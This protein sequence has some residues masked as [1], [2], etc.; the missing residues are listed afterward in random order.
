MRHTVPTSSAICS[1]L[2]RRVAYHQKRRDIA[3]GVEHTLDVEKPAAGIRNCTDRQELFS[4][5]MSGVNS[6]GVA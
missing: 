6:Y 5:I 1:G 3:H 4:V 2:C